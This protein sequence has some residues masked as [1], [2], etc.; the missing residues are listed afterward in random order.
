MPNSWSKTLLFISMYFSLNFI[1]KM[2]RYST[3][4]SIYLY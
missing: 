4:E 3:G 1:I 2:L